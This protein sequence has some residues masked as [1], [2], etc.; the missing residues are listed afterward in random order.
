M[1]NDT[2]QS[3]CSYVIWTDAERKAIRILALT[4]P[5]IPTAL[6][7]V[8][9][10]AVKAVLEDRPDAAFMDKLGR[11]TPR[12]R[13]YDSVGRLLDLEHWLTTG[14][15]RWGSRLPTSPSARWISQGQRARPYMLRLAW[16]VDQMDRVIGVTLVDS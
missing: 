1:A 9:D 10:P 14:Q 16:E 13:W 11:L 8:V 15:L 12:W 4:D 2:V 3:H 6:G 7:E 5:G